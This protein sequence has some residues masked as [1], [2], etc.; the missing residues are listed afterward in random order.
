[1]EYEIYTNTN[2]ISE[3]ISNLQPKFIVLDNITVKTQPNSSTCGI[4]SITIITNYY[5]KTNFGVND[6]IK[7]Y[8]VNTSKGSTFDD[9]KRWLQG[10]MPEKNIVLKANETNVEMIRNIHSSLNN[11][12]PVLISFGAPNPYNKPFYDFHASVV[13]GINLN[14]ETILIA[15]AYGYLEEISLTEFLNRMSVTE[16]DKY[17]LIHQFILINNRRD[18]NTYY[19]IN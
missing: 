5:N 11:N 14:N 12:N 10:E 4:T 19:L 16:I 8:N 18:L 15:N 3:I 7:K 2:E 9:M 1:M 17:P 13:Y 6:L